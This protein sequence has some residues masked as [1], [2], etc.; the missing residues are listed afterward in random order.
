MGGLNIGLKVEYLLLGLGDRFGILFRPEK[1]IKKLYL[2][3][4][5]QVLDYG[6]DIGSY[7]FPAPKLVGEKGKVYALDRNRN[8]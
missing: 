3:R 7:T 5:Q 1:E 2:R 8:S 6:C 4:E